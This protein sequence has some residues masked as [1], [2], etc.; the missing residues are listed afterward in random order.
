MSSDAG[1]GDEKSHSSDF[2]SREL[3]DSKYGGWKARTMEALDKK[4]VGVHV[5]GTTP[6]PAAWSGAADDL[7]ALALN[8]K[9]INEWITND[10]QARAIISSRLPFDHLHLVDAATTSKE[11]WDAITLKYEQKRSTAAVASTIQ[12]LFTKRWD[13]GSLEQHISWFRSTNQLLARYEPGI[14]LPKT[15]GAAVQEHVLAVALCCSISN[16]AEWAAVKANIHATSL[17]RFEDVAA[18]LMGECHRQQME[19]KDAARRAAPPSAPTANYSH[20]HSGVDDRNNERPLCPHC[21]KRGHKADKCWTEYPELAPAFVQQRGNKRADK[22]DKKANKRTDKKHGKKDNRAAPARHESSSDEESGSEWA[23]SR[24]C[25]VLAEED[26]D[27][28]ATYERASSAATVTVATPAPASAA[29][30]ATMR[31]SDVNGEMVSI[32]SAGIKGRSLA[33]DWFVDSAASLHY[34]NQRE[35]FDTFEPTAGKGRSVILG[36]GRRIPVAGCGTIKMTVSVFG[37]LKGGI[38]SNVQYTPDMAVNLLS[39]PVLTEAGLETRFLGRDCT[40][41]RGR[42][43]IARACKVA[44]RLF[45]L[46]MIKRVKPAARSGESQAGSAHVAQADLAQLWHQRLGHPNFAALKKLFAEQQVRDEPGVNCEEIARALS[47]P[48]HVGKCEACAIAKSASKPFPPSGTTRARRPLELIHMDLCTLPTRSKAG[49]KHF[50]TI[51]DDNSCELWAFLLRTKDEALPSYRAWV[52]AAEAKHSAAG[53]K[54]L[55]VR[56][57]NGGE[58]IS[59]AFDALLAERGTLRERSTPYTPQQNGVAER[60]NRTLLNSVRAMLHDSRLDASFWDEALGTA[61][62]VHNRV[63][64]RALGGITPHR[65]WTGKKPRIGHIRAFGCL[66]FAHVPKVERMKLAPRARKCVLVGYEHDMRAYRLWDV[67]AKAIIVSRDVDFWEGVSWDVETAGRGGA[68]PA[69]AGTTL[70]GSSSSSTR[71]NP[72]RAVRGSTDST[73]S[74]TS[75]SETGSTDSTESDTSASETDSDDGDVEPDPRPGPADP[76]EK[77]EAAA[78]EP[79]SPEPVAEP[80][81]EAKQ[82]ED[83]EKQPAEAAPQPRRRGRIAKGDPRFLKHDLAVLRDRNAPAVNDNA[84][85]LV[86]P[87]ALATC[88][89]V[90]AGPKSYREAMRGSSAQLWRGPCVDEIGKLK[91]MQTW[92][93]VPRRA[94]MNVVGNTWRLKSKYNAQG[95]LVSRKAR[96]CAKGFTQRPGVD[97]TETYSPVVRY[98]SLRGLL[99]LA[100]QHDWDVHHMDVKSAFLNGRLKETVYMAQPEGFVEKGK[101][102]WVCLLEKGLYGLKQSGRVWNQ[103]ADRFLRKLGFKPLEADRCVYVWRDGARMAIV[104]L[105]VDDMFLFTPR[106]SELMQRLKTR[107]QKKFEMTDLGE[108]SEALGVEITRDRGARTLTITQRRHA[109]GILEGAGMADCAAASTPMAIGTQLCLPEEGFKATAVDTLRYQ[110]AMGELNY[111]VSWT[112]PDIAFAVSALSKYSSN[113]GPQHFAGLR[114]VYRYLRGTQD[115]G[116]TY[117]GAGDVTDAPTLTIYSDAD[118]AA[119]MDDRRSVTGYSVHLCGAAVSWLSTRQS[120]TAQSTVEAEY[121]SSAEAVKEA[122]WWRAFLRGMGHRLRA[123]TVLYSDNQGSIA[124]SKNPDSHRRTKHIDVRYHLLRE[125]VERGTVTVQ[126]VSTKAMPADMLTKGLPPLM[127]RRCAELLGIGA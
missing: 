49:F 27:D 85:S 98:P 123:P 95:E 81:D 112:R 69:A 30:P 44:N 33:S 16:T 42:K 48:A 20:G 86:P 106:N 62:Y 17:F 11:L 58:F 7:S 34:C 110:R 77:E 2:D 82:S 103:V 127:H 64:T 96:L 13:G 6:R 23:G 63:P 76:E 61:V 57:D 5:D 88:D 45:Q 121:M 70:T 107:L 102:D 84:P 91:K 99:A 120:T 51:Q 19:A 1:V 117:T 122:I 116:V 38:L 119:C 111:L 79:A 40:I 28:D 101:E 39:V 37:R 35:M 52:A 93:L 43:V 15:T 71:Q 67:E 104:S 73:E 25:A 90:Q 108:V 118:F 113:P 29:A 14:Q 12:E 68:A 100:A 126:Y 36:D 3:D 83:D 78:L 114:H 21:G 4:K 80:D 66:C 87:R 75:A 56:S 54:V 97:Y 105:Y 89:D 59:G 8:Q 32:H 50:L 22:A 41:R 72:R 46:T 26:G 94:G 18:R 9:A 109:R 24:H 60:V 65:A 125:H 10:R 115:Y 53:H 55:A 92:R 31:A 124:L 74:D 47:N